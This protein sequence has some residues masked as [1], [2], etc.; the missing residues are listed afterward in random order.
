M[1]KPGIEIS[2]LRIE[3]DHL[4]ARRDIED[5]LFLAV[6][7]VRQAPARQLARRDFAAFPFGKTEHPAHLAV[8]RIQRH[9][10]AA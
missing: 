5:S 10:R 1:P 9:D 8:G 3:G 2:G 6:A 7:P 4:V